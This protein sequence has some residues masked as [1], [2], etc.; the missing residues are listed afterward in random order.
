[1]KNVARGMGDLRMNESSGCERDMNET[2]E[3]K[4]VDD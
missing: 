1:M 4:E 3:K 2:S